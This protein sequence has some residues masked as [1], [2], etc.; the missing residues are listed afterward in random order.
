MTKDQLA[1]LERR[2]KEERAR[3][4]EILRRFQVD[5]GSDEARDQA[6]DLTALPFHPAD[7][8]TDQQQ[9]EVD[10]AIARRE[11]ATLA[12]IDAALE[13]LYR[14]PERFGR[15]E[16]SGEPIS[17]ARLDLVPWARTGVNGGPGAPPAR[18]TRPSELGP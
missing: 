14:E 2:L 5:A 8:G 4:A 12:E 15:D 10:D 6:G 7:L 13:R 1:Y 9:R 3:I 16:R 11:A 17:F 18:E